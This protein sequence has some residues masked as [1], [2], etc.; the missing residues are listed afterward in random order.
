[1]G[2]KANITNLKVKL[3]AFVILNAYLKGMLLELTSSVTG[4]ERKKAL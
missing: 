2:S 1:V 3:Q 4:E